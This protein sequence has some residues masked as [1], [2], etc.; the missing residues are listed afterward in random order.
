MS[1]FDKLKER[2]DNV[3]CQT[4]ARY[5][6]AVKSAKG[7]RLYD[8]DGNEYLDLL[9]G[10]AVMSLGHC[11]PEVAR[12][13]SEQTHKLWHVSNLFYQEEQV[14]LAEKLVATS[15][16]K[17]VFFCNSGAE[18]NE[19][20]FK[21]SRRY[22]QKIKHKDAH[23]VIS[24]SGCFHGRT[25]STL[26][27]G[28]EKYREGFL[29]MP[30]GFTQIVRG[31]LAALEKAITPATAAV[32]MEIVQ[33][34]GGIYPMDPEFAKGVQALCRKNGVLFLVD[35]VQ[36]GMGRSGKWWAFQRYGLEPDAF[37]LAKAVAGGLP[38]GAM[39]CSDELAKAF[40]FGSHGTT[41]GG[42]PICAAAG[43]KVM[44]IMERDKLPQRAGEMGKWALERF[45]RIQA[46]LPGA[47][48]EVRG[49]GLLLGIDL[50]FPGKPIWEA[51][52]KKGFVLNLTQ[53]TVLRLLPPLNI[54]RADLEAFAV[55][56][57]EVLRAH[58]A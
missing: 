17:R 58:Q 23:E 37:S 41:F 45:A 55:A 29:P 1:N 16:C 40:D 19:A 9:A 53:D 20:L 34:E 35:E 31:D 42:N 50:T 6:I 49:L 56:L 46:D 26:A 4:Y 38:M 25:M 24:F 28:P 52:L 11:H 27:V 30:V 13:V 36:T 7:G 5:P 10:L 54:E 12:V 44:E 8:F 57:E 39:L 32:I 22:Q 21:I 14:A 18:A 47:I 3:L 33:G 43:C 51:L 2:A 15:H 48:K